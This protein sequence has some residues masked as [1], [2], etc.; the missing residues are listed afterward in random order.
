MYRFVRQDISLWD[1]ISWWCWW[2]W[3]DTRNRVGRLQCLCQ[4]VCCSCSLQSISHGGCVKLLLDLLSYIS[5]LYGLYTART[6]NSRRQ[7]GTFTN[8]AFLW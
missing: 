2:H 5:A 6:T 1:C 3:F 4:E 8:N 7:S